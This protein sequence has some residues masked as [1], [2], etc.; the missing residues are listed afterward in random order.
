MI[1]RALFFIFILNINL[2]SCGYW[3]DP[4]EKEF[5]FLDD[6]N[7]PLANYSNL[8]E[9]AVYNTIIYEYE[10]KNKEA[11]LKEW[12]EELKN[13]YSIEN[14][15]DFI[16]KRKNLNLLRDNEISEY[17]KFV[18]KQE[19]CVTYDYYKPVPTGCEGYI[20]EALN[21]IDKTTSQY[22]KLRYFYLAFR[23]AHFKQQEPL[24]IYEKYKYLLQDDKKT[25]VKD[26]IQ[27]IYAGA[28]IKNGETVKGV[29]EFSKLLDESK[30]N[31]HLSYYNFFHIKTNEQWNEL[32]AKAQNNEEKTKFYALRSLKPESN[33]LEELEN[34]KKVDV[35]SK[36][37]DFVLFRELLNYQLFFNQNEETVVELPK[38]YIEFLKTI[39]RDDMYLVNLSLAYFSIFQKNY[40]EASKYSKELLEKYPDSHEAQ[41]LAYILYLEKLQKIDIKTENEIYTKMTELTKKDHTSQSIHDYTFVILEKLYKKQNDKFNAFLSKHINYLDMSAF[42]LEL[43]ERF[44]VFMKLTPDSK[45]KEYMQTSFSKQVNNHSYATKTRLLIN[46]LKFQEA[47]ETNTP[48]LNEKIEFNPFNTFIKGNN[49][50]S[51]QDVLTI[52]EFLTKMIVI[53]TEL[54][55]NPKSVMDNYL[56]ANALYNLSYF[57]NSDRITTV[58]RSNYSI[59]SPLL[60]KEK[61]E[62][63]IK[64]YN[65][66][67]ENSKDKEFQAKLTYMISKAYLALADLSNEKDRW[68]Y[69]GESKYNYGTIYETFLQ[70]NGAKYFDTLKQ[71]FGNTKYYQELIQ[72]CGDFKIYQKGKQ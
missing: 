69:Y 51:K 71:D 17:I 2:F 43:M 34:I 15:E 42:D 21:N 11:N 30:I 45:L 33:I 25:I 54:E 32:L 10:R 49:R 16:Y 47:L 27:G 1:L 57:G 12:Q 8:D 36:W 59:G 23:L 56:F 55:K 62:K 14:I 70:K 35:N 48:F 60:Q 72:Q 4:Y 26:W 46:N 31:S 61:L 53:K 28:L 6:R 29:Y 44:E 3:I 65:I 40:V 52:K 68:K 9:A 37:L 18:E 7:S 19:S 58:Y 64:H 39:K 66:A 5:I 20:N 41:T 13:R 24:K 63:A 38:K 22:L 67:L 50:T